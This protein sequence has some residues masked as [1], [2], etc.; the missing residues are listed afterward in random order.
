MAYV[1]PAKPSAT[2]NLNLLTASGHIYA[3]LLSEISENKSSELDL[4]L[5][6]ETD[7]PTRGCT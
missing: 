1:K 7:E 2:T 5:Y 4:A 6:L 3:F